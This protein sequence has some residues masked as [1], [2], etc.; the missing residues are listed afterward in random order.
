MYLES[1]KVEEFLF[2]EVRCEGYF[3]GGVLEFEGRHCADR[4]GRSGEVK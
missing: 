1:W 2:G 3:D 4:G